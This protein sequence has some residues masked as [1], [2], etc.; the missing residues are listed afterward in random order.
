MCCLHRILYKMYIYILYGWLVH[1]LSKSEDNTIRHNKW[2]LLW[3]FGPAWGWDKSNHTVVHGTFTTGL[4]SQWYWYLGMGAYLTL[5][6]AY[7]S[8]TQ[9]PFP[10]IFDSGLGSTV[11]LKPDSIFEWKLSLL[12]EDIRIVFIQAYVFCLNW[13]MHRST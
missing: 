13:F 1:S 4:H 9:C 11:I 3:A 12:A 6:Y 5:L 10:L 2:S 7:I 8:G